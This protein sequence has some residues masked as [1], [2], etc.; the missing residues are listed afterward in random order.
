MG[1]KKN[2]NKTTNKQP[3]NQTSNGKTGQNL[4]EPKSDVSNL[5]CLYEIVSLVVQVNTDHTLTVF[6][7]DEQA[8][9]LI[10]EQCSHCEL[11]NSSLFLLSCSNTDQ[12]KSFWMNV[13]SQWKGKYKEWI[14]S[15]LC[16]S[17]GRKRENVCHGRTKASSNILGAL[18]QY[19]KD[20]SRNSYLDKMQAKKE[21]TVFNNAHVWPQFL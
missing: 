5:R 17:G 11:H 12:I 9:S 4:K 8:C 14:V 7:V 13:P 6:S 10:V 15:V 19:F 2:Q 18:M 20:F 16:P 1:E 21:S 3:K